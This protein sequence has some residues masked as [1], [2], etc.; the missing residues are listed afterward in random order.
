MQSIYLWSVTESVIGAMHISCRHSQHLIKFRERLWSN[1]MCENSFSWRSAFHQLLQDLSGLSSQ[2][3]LAFHSG[4]DDNIESKNNK[5]CILL[6]GKVKTDPHHW[7]R[8]MD[9][10]QNTIHPPKSPLTSN[11]TE[12]H[13]LFQTCLNISHIQTWKWEKD[14]FLK[15][16]GTNTLL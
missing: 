11:G 2:W 15:R 10:T 14:T 7:G 16:Y 1:I 8:F 4:G 12:A 9:P 13:W 3:I 5:M 6:L